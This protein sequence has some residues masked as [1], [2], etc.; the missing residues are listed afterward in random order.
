MDPTNLTSAGEMTIVWS[1]KGGSGTTV[2]A[3]ALA[4]VRAGSGARVLLVDLAGDMPAALGMATP[5]GPGV[6]DWL[7]DPDAEVDAIDRLVLPVTEGL[8]LLPA[9]GV[10]RRRWSPDRSVALAAALGGRLASGRSVVV[11]AGGCGGP[12]VSADHDDLVVALAGP[13]RSLMVTR[14]CYLA[15]RAAM[16]AQ[17]VADGVVVIAEPGRSLNDRDVSDVLSVPVVAS[18]VADPAIARAVDAGLLVR[19]VPRVLAREL[20]PLW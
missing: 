5:S 1:P 12:V 8:A 3:A 15:L 14:S 18:I 10:G 6:L 19:R 4:V 13:G 20:G 2:V 11:D 7:A 17:V 16:N 9:G